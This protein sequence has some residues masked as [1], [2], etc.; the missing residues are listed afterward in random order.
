MNK[1]VIITGASSGIGLSLKNKYS[2]SGD[3]VYN[4]SRNVTEDD[5]NYKS[6]V[7][8]ENKM[9]EIINTIGTKH[10]HID[11]LINCAGFGVS[12]AI[13]LTKSADYDSIM[14]TNVKG[15]FVTTKLALPYLNK[16]AYIIN[17]S[18]TCALFPVPYRGLY[19]ASKSAVS[20]LSYSLR[21]E[22]KQ[23]GIKVV[24]ICPGEIKTNFTKNRVKN[25]DTNYRYGRRIADAS[26]AIDRKDGKRMSPNVVSNKIYSITSKNKNKPMIII[27]KKMKFLYFV[28]K[29]LPLRFWLYITEKFM[30]GNKKFDDNPYLND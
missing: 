23:S 15:V 3:I 10:G 4:I 9:R 29:F 5:Y 24:T 25:F 26:Y 2:S 6:D 16:G 20:M 12:G 21:M 14:S 17:I 13:E 7:A 1:V 11:I 8:D 27:G 22:L 30:G 28:S 18:S 19:C